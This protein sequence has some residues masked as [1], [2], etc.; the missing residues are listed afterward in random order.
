TDLVTRE[1]I[2]EVPVYK[3]LISADPQ[4]DL[5]KVAAVNRRQ[6]PGKCF[7]GFIKGFGIKCGALA[8]S[9]AWDVSDIIA[10]GADEADM[11][12]AINR[13][14]ETGGGI[15]AV[16]NGRVVAQMSQPV[17]GT[18]SEMPMGKIVECGRDLKS[19]AESF[20]IKF[21]DPLLSLHTLTGA[22]IP[23]LRICEQ[24]L[25]DLKTG[26]TLDLFV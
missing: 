23:F 13:I 9:S 6:A 19:A 17:F 2:I 22:A 12:A 7:T 4:N 3:G 26:A 1:K 18:I 20:G 25:V 15:V 10:A 21:P 14:R 8:S 24:G 5:A 16:K 11:A